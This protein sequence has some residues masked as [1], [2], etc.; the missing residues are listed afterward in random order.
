MARNLV[1][2][3][4]VLNRSWAYEITAENAVNLVYGFLAL[5]DNFN[6]PGFDEK[7]QGAMNALIACAPRIASPFV[8]LFFAFKRSHLPPRSPSHTVPL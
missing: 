1:R 7:R 3:F 2:D 6:S 8:S 5:H 4:E